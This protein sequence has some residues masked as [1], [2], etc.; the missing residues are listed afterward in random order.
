MGRYFY[1]NVSV[2]NTTSP[3]DDFGGMVL[4][5]ANIFHLGIKENIEWIDLIRLCELCINSCPHSQL[6]FFP[7]SDIAT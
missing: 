6:E 4:R 1:A 5:G 7:F 2:S 3:L